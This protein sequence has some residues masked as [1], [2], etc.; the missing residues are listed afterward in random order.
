MKKI[1]L[2]QIILLLFSL[3]KCSYISALILPDT[4]I[5]VQQICYFSKEAKEV[6]LVWGINNWNIINEELRPEG[7]FIKENFLY[8]PMKLNKKVFSVNL[9]LHPKTQVDYKFLITKGPLNKE[10]EIWDNNSSYQKHYHA[11]TLSDNTVIHNSKIKIRP[12]ASLT[13]LDFSMPFLSISCSFLLL[14]LIIRERLYSDKQLIPEFAKI[15]ISGG[16]V[17]FVV[18]ALIRSSVMGFSW[19]L[20]LHPFSYVPKLI[21]AGFYDLVYIGIVCGVFLI[22][23]QILGKLP[24]AKIIQISLFT[25][26][27]LVSILTAIVNSNEAEILG[28]SFSYQKFYIIE[29][30]GDVTDLT[31]HK[32]IQIISVCCA[33][34][35]STA[36]LSFISEL[37]IQKRTVKHKI[38]SSFVC[39]SFVYLTIAPK[40][41]KHYSWE[42][43]K[44][45]NPI[46]SFFG[47][48]EFLPDKKL[49]TMEA[50]DSLKTAISKNTLVTEQHISE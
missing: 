26:I 48:K 6:Y 24:Y 25:F 46:V 28:Q 34:V 37:V 3:F 14:L 13:I 38:I 17:L 5:V 33:S 11:I 29:G 27:G 16:I 42:Y 22:T 32:I 39:A 44:M 21:W 7:S 40:A 43:E 49:F 20:Y 18:L 10:V 12:R 30:I 9:K 50:S 4:Q 15:I 19:E 31:F 23:N 8:T 35:F 41:I 47:K 45:A 1:K 2:L 36:F